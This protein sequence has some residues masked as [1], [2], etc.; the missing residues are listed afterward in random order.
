MTPASIRQTALNLLANREHSAA[1]LTKKLRLKGFEAS[2]IQQIITTLEQE[3]L[4]SNARFVEN[5]IRYR[6]NKGYGPLY[7]QA[8]LIERGICQE[9]IEQQLDIADNAWFAEIFR[10]WQKR[11]KNKMPDDYKSRA[12]QMR[13]LQYRGFTREQIES[14][15]EST[16]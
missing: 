9:L 7:I 4:L 11:F 15:F 8:Q 14:V 16:E 6:R 10:V 1:E 12:Q 3:G 13:F 2:A 5:F